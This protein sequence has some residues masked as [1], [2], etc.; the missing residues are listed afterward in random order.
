MGIGN[1][2]V[3]QWLKNK[4]RFA[5]LFNGFV[6]D[7]KQVIRPEELEEC[8]SESDVII[9]DKDEKEKGVRRYRDVVM[10][11]KKD[12]ELAVL[13]CENQQKVHYAMPVRTMLYDSLSYVEQIRRI[14]KDKEEQG[15]KRELAREEYL[16]RFRKSDRIYPVITL[17]LYYGSEVWDMNRD[18][19][20]M[21]RLN[22]DADEKE[23]MEKYIPNYHINLIDAER[24]ENLERFKTDL[25]VIFNMIKYRDKKDSLMKYVGE[26]IDFFENVDRETYQAC[27][28]FLSAKGGMLKMI[29]SENEEK[30]RVNMCKALEELYADGVAE[31]KTNGELNKTKTVVRNMLS[32]GMA[33]ADICALAECTPEFV[34]EIR[35]TV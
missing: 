5:D 35:Q 17:V 34:E 11:W 8:D 4:T 18:L 2:S 23:V 10:R 15:D 30:E 9:S 31:G 29:V 7:G 14:W 28:E 33:E 26:H 1:I 16:S 19:Y 13:A 20:E 3:R 32:R 25:Q 6:F 22:E 27:R 24:L 21:F 12:R